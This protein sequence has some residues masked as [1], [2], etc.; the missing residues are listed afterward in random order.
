MNVAAQRGRL[1]K[2]ALADGHHARIRCA[3]GFLRAFAARQA[4]HEG[5]AAHFALSDLAQWS[6]AGV[7]AAGQELLILGWCVWWTLLAA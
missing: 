6:A 2:T 5:W 3:A 1:L 4:S 7:A